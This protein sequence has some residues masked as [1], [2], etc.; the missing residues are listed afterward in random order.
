QFG[1]GHAATALPRGV[2]PPSPGP[3]ARM[4]E[5]PCRGDRRPMLAPGGRTHPLTV[6]EARRGVAVQRCGLV[7]RH[8]APRAEFEID[9]HRRAQR[10][11]AIPEAPLPTRH[12]D[13]LPSS[14]C[15]L[16]PAP[17]HT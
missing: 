4:L 16:R 14:P 17:P 13:R 12:R 7:D 11:A 10:L 1:A 3:R 8:Q 5:Y 15:A 2:D 9:A 6:E